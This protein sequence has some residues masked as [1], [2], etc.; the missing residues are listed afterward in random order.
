ML[1]ITVVAQVPEEVVLKIEG[2]LTQDEA[3][4]LEQEGTN[5]YRETERLVLDLTGIKVIDG[6]GLALLK[7]W[8]GER[9]ELRGGSPFIQLLL[10]THGLV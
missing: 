5:W 6:C 1:R 4:V 3:A 8:V 2:Q 9:L 10:R 7:R